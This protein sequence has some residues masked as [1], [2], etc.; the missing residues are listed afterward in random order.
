MGHSSSNDNSLPST[1][2]V[3]LERKSI[4]EDERRGILL[5]GTSNGWERVRPCV[6]GRLRGWGGGGRREGLLVVVR[7]RWQWKRLSFRGGWSVGC[8]VCGGSG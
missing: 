5:A 6:G 4:A 3:L 2:W 8:P 1:H 7:L